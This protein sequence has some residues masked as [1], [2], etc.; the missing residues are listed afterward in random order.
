MGKK[1]DAAVLPTDAVVVTTAKA[2]AKALAA[3][4]KK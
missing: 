1:A 2:K 3:Q 4:K